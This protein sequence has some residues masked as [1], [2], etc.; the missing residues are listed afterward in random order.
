MRLHY[1]I[2]IILVKVWPKLFERYYKEYQLVA[3]KYNGRIR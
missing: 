3:E 1:Y 2:L